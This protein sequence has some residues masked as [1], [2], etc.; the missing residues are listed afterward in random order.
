MH[1]TIEINHL[2]REEKI[3]IMEAIWNDLSSDE[4][5]VESPDWHKEALLETERRFSSGQEEILDWQNA[6]QELRKR[7]E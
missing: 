3:M 6:K 4:E 1:K 5:Q 2:S 7:S